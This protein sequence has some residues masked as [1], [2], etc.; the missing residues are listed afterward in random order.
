[1]TE[2][3]AAYKG[4]IPADAD[5]WVYEVEEQIPDLTPAEL[6]AS[7]LSLEEREVDA[8]RLVQS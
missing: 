1:M 8:V 5:D 6:E 2:T 7:F 3:I 4:F